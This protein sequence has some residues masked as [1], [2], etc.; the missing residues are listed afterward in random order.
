[1][2]K[3]FLVER[4]LKQM[5][6]RRTFPYEEIFLSIIAHSCSFS[7][8]ETSFDSGKLEAVNAISHTALST[9]NLMKKITQNPFGSETNFHSNEH[10]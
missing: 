6:G 7:V 5:G 8:V 2:H 10:R 3:I 1:M 4:D 9:D